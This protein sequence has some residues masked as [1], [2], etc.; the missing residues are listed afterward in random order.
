LVYGY[1]GTKKGD[2]IFQ[3]KSY[4]TDVIRRVANSCY[5]SINDECSF[6]RKE[7]YPVFVNTV[8]QKYQVLSADEL[9]DDPHKTR[10]FFINPMALYYKSSFLLGPITK[11]F[12]G[13]A[14]NCIGWSWPSGVAHYFYGML[15]KFPWIYLMDWD[16]SKFDMSLK[17]LVLGFIQGVSILF[18]DRNSKWYALLKNYI[19]HEVDMDVIKFVQWMD[20]LWRLVIGQNFSGKYTTSHSNTE[21]SLICIITWLLDSADAHLEDA[22]LLYDC[23]VK[24]LEWHFDDASTFPPLGVLLFGDDGLFWNSIQKLSYL[25]LDSWMTFM[26]SNFNMEIKPSNCGEYS[27]LLSRVDITG[28]YVLKEWRFRGELRNIPE[29]PVFLKRRFILRKYLSG[30]RCV[31]FRSVDDYYAR[32]A[33]TISMMIE[34][35]YL[36]L[37]RIHGLMFDSMGTNPFAYSF[38]SILRNN[39]ST[40]IRVKYPHDDWPENLKLVGSGVTMN[41]EARRLYD[42]LQKGGFGDYV[43]DLTQ[44]PSWEKLQNVMDV[45]YVRTW[46]YT[47]E[48]PD[49]WENINDGEEFPSGHYEM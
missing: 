44:C 39:V 3:I 26:K 46:R 23:V 8:T 9:R 16:I 35:P 18:F 49:Y 36:E 31:P 22:S 48:R 13:R 34:N 11:L 43:P 15:K 30:Y 45:D 40:Y 24:L 28:R 29:G 38:L 19:S 21:Y 37:C 1:S 25:N 2:A 6:Y 42:K 17:W 27:T 41:V 12:R 10:M 7:L 47:F 20:D 5:F 4:I 14:G 33:K 32:A